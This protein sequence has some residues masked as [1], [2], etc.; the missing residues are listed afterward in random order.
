[1]FESYR[2]RTLDL[3]SSGETERVNCI[4]AEFGSML[5]AYTG[6]PSGTWKIQVSNTEEPPTTGEWADL[7]GAT[8]SAGTS[9][10][11]INLGQI[12]YRWARVVYTRVSGTGT[13]TIHVCLKNT[14]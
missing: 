4:G 9:P 5:V 11:F 1:M 13:A 12:T 3:S 14:Y 7:S 10:G 2:Q 6:S 8:L